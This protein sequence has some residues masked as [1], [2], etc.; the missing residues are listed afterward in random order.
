MADNETQR[1]YPRIPTSNWWELRRRFAQSLP[2]TVDEDYLQSVLGLQNRRSA[3]NLIAPLRAVGLIDEEGRP[4]D[5]GNDW[6]SDDHYAKVCKQIVDEVY[7]SGLRDA[8]PPPK[9]SLDGVKGWFS[10]NAKVGESTAV[11]MASL[12]LLIAE[13]DALASRAT[14]KEKPASGPARPPKA[15]SNRSKPSKGE[16]TQKTEIDLGEV[17]PPAAVNDHRLPSLHID[18]QIHI[19]ADASP[20]QIDA[21]F[22]SMAKHLYQRG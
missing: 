5:R 12:Y 10:R 7:P 19:A 8:F 22:E 18:V 9:P 16:T 21:V 15:A 2:K 4:T 6:R 13:G 11:A 14:V 3:A 17:K 20:D 1:K